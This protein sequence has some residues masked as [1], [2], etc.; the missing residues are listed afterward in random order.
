MWGGVYGFVGRIVAICFFMAF[1]LMWMVQRFKENRRIVE[2][3]DEIIRK[4]FLCFLSRG[5]QAASLKELEQATGLTKGAFYYYFKDKRELLQAGL[6]L[7]WGLMREETGEEVEAA[8]SLEAY[9]RLVLAHKE[10]SAELSERE[11]GC[12]VPEAFFFQLVLE[13][14]DLFPAV[15]AKVDALAKTRLRH[16]ERVIERAQARGEVRK[17]LDAAVL[18]RNLMSVSVSMLNLELKGTDMR[19]VFS[20]MRAQFEQYYALVKR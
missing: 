7:Y 8:E 16:W 18:A 19:F 10:E 20:D 9:I 14:E 4:T 1:F 11:L 12:S 5:Y 13:V 15:G 6:E 2:L 17:E 3:R